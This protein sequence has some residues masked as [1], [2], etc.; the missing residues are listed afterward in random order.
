[1]FTGFPEP[2]ELL[3]LGVSAALLLVILAKRLFTPWGSFFAFCMAM[4]IGL[5]G[6][7]NALILLMILLATSVVA[8]RYK[9][10]LKRR[11]G[12]QEGRRGERGVGS[13]LANGGTAMLIVVLADPSIGLLSPASASVAYTAAIAVAGS[14]TIASELG[15]LSKKAYLITTFKRVKPGTDGGISLPGTSWA[16]LAALYISVTG[17]FML[18]R[19]YYG[20]EVILIPL[21]AGIFGCMLDSVIGA[22]LERGK[23]IGK[24]GNNFVSITAG[25]VVAWVWSVI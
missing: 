22:T 20:P 3:I 16:I 7:L 15:V 14:D 5:F 25:A 10:H 17:Y 6:G 1:M 13:L 12:V 11:L 8:T 4:V 21:C 2:G 24:N 9:F 18:M 23:R 19:G